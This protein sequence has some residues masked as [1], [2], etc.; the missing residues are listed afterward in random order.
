VRLRWA[1]DR[2]APVEELLWQHLYSKR[3]DARYEIGE[4]RGRAQ[5]YNHFLYQSGWTYQGRTIGTPLFL[6]SNGRPGINNNIVVAQHVGLSGTLATVGYRA[7]VTYSRNYGACASNSGTC[8]PEPGS[9]RQRRDQWSLLLEGT[10]TLRR[11]VGGQL[12]LRLGAAL[13][14]GSV[15][16]RKVGVQAGVMWRSDGR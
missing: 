13:D 6:T 15:Y 14:L 5:Y 12:Q 8:P 10:R 1:D 11:V 16:A 7:L 3:Q 9:F 2:T 4:V